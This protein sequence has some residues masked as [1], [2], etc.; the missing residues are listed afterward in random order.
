M[1]YTINFDTEGVGAGILAALGA[2]LLV[3]VLIALVISIVVIIGQWKALKK[4]GK[5]GWAAIIPIYNNWVMCEMVGVNPYWVIV[6]LLSPILALIP[7]VGSLIQ[8]VV[9]LYFTILLNVSVARSFGK[10]DGY[11]AGLILLPVIFWPMLGF[12]KDE[13]VGAKPMDDV[14]YNK[15]KEITKKN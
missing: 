7:V 10:S 3:I 8:F 2:F 9:A 5:P 11:A 15:F 13:F 4:G 12:G 6:V 1:N 14:A